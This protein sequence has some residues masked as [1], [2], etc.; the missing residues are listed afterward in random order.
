MRISD[1]SSDVCSSDLLWKIQPPRP[2]NATSD[3]ASTTCSGMLLRRR[4]L[5]VFSRSF[6]PSKVPRGHIAVAT[7]SSSSAK[8]PQYARNQSQEIG[9]AQCR[10][11]VGKYS[12]ITVADGTLQKKNR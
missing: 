10:D 12:E 5:A 7:P 4:S 1:W 3:A 9:R 8:A 11:R 2:M 6:Q